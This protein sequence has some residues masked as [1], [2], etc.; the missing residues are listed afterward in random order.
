MRCGAFD[1]CMP[2][3]RSG[4]ATASWILLIGMPDVSEAM[5]QSGETKASISRNT[6]CFSSR[7]SGTFSITRS[8]PVTQSFRVSTTAGATVCLFGTPSASSTPHARPNPSLALARWS[9]LASWAVTVRPQRASVAAMPGPMVPRPMTATLFIA[10]SAL[11]R[12]LEGRHGLELVAPGAQIPERRQ[13]DREIEAAMH[14]R[15]EHDI[16]QSQLL[17]G[18]VGFGHRAVQDRELC[19]QL[20]GI[21]AKGRRAFGGV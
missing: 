19:R 1:Q 13:I 8:A 11:R 12:F 21:G 10:P 15:A 4:V 20:L 6:L 17:A 2:M 14:D 7:F 18:D 16:G 3:T 9:A 5:M